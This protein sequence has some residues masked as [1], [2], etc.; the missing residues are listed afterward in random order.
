MYQFYLQKLRRWPL[1]ISKHNG[2]VGA[3]A[4][5]LETIGGAKLSRISTI[6]TYICM[7]FYS[8]FP[9]RYREMTNCFFYC[10][11]IC[12]TSS[13]HAVHDGYFGVQEK[14]KLLPFR[15]W[16]CREALQSP[17]D[18]TELV[19][20]S[21]LSLP[22]LLCIFSKKFFSGDNNNKKSSPEPNFLPLGP[23]QYDG[24]DERTTGESRPIPFISGVIVHILPAM[25]R[26]NIE[27]EKKRKK[28]EEE[29]DRKMKGI[30]ERELE[31][32][33]RTSSYLELLSC[34]LLERRQERYKQKSQTDGFWLWGEGNIRYLL[35][36][37]QSVLIVH[38][39]ATTLPMECRLLNQRKERGGEKNPILSRPPPPP[40]SISSLHCTSTFFTPF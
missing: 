21:L 24:L 28:K 18:K 38:N 4:V 30:G 5:A 37:W 29:A 20:Y 34:N 39:T 12:I 1:V 3:L 17:G 13:S 8:S 32:R 26:L 31:G 16:P 40:H 23:I 6:L 11:M 2:H 25:C 36:K 35:A 33:G 7:I 14:K 19:P 27:K 10:I 15:S 9:Y 22:C